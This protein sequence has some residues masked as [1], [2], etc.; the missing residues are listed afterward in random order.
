MRRSGGPRVPTDLADF[1]GQT[2]TSTYGGG[3]VAS[4]V[5]AGSGPNR[6][7][8][9]TWAVVAAA[10]VGAALLATGCEDGPNQTLKPAPSGA[11][12]KWN[13]GKTKG[14][15]DDQA[16][17]GFAADF[18]GGANKQ[19]I[20]TGEQRA[21]RWAKM[22]TEPI[23]PPTKAAGI[24][25]VGG[26]AWTGMTVEQAEK[27]N[28]QS[29]T[30]GDQFGDGTLVNAWGDQGEVWI[31]YDI[32]NHNKIQWI[33]LW[34]G[35]VGS[36]DFTSRNGQ[37]K[38]VIQIGTQITKNGKKYPIDWTDPAK[39]NAVATEIVDALFA[40]YAPDLPAE[41]ITKGGCI[42]N[43][44]CTQTVFPEQG[45]LRIWPLGLHIWVN[46][47]LA[48]QPTPSTFMR[49]DMRLP[50]VMPF[51]LGRPELKLDAVGPTTSIK[52]LGASP[53]KPGKD[54]TISL[55]MTWQALLDGCV[56]VTGDAK[57]DALNYNKLT[58]NITHDAETFVFD[59]SGVD[60]DFVSS[61]LGPFD[62]LRDQDRPVPGDKAARLTF[63]AN[64]LGHFAN[65]WSADD[66][67]NDLHGSGAVYFE[68]AKL[69][70]A[71]IN[72]QLQ[73]ADPAAPTHELGDPACLWPDDLSGFDPKTFDY[74]KNCTGFEGFV[75]A[76]PAAATAT[77]ANPSNRIR[78][79]A[80]AGQ[81]I[82]TLGLKPGKP[83]AAFCMD[84]TGDLQTGYVNCGASDPY[85]RS[86]SLWD[87]S[88]DRVREVLGK[89]DV[90]NLPPEI[91]DRRFYFKMYVYALLKYMMGSSDGQKLDVDAVPVD[92]NELFFDSEGAGQYELAEYVDRRFVSATQEP[93][94]FVVKADILNGTLY[95]YNFDR[96]LNRDEK[97]I[98]TALTENKGDPPGKENDLTLTNVF[99]S[100]VLAGAYQDTATRTAY[101]CATATWKTDAEM[102]DTATACTND[103]GVAQ[104]P[105]LDP[106]YVADPSDK[107]A[108]MV[109]PLL[110][111][112][113]PILAPYKGA[114]AGRSTVF[115]L[116]S[117]KL[118]IQATYPNLQAAKVKINTSSD[119]Y[120][121][122]SAPGTPIEVLVE[123][124][125]PPQPGYGFLWPLNGQQDKLVQAGL[126]DFSG[127][128]T[129]FNLHYQLPAGAPADGT[130]PVNVMAVDSID[131]L[132]E[133]FLCMDPYTRDLLH[134]GMYD[135]VATV[136]DWIDKHPGAQQAC[137]LIVRYSPYANFPD[138]VISTVNGVRIGVT[139]GGGYGRVNDASLWLP[140]EY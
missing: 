28:C 118:E 19:E 47:P 112:G 130:G 13:D 82:G 123:P 65:D 101:Q 89:G 137:G 50:R 6:S 81:I 85:G 119:P 87:T 98:Y 11:A 32:A 138:Y 17:Q 64:T 99:G 70:Q 94:D 103:V 132:G 96:L 83:L 92:D 95:D 48:P 102:Q 43:G 51:T 69:V 12:D 134:V 106:F 58:G 61:A 120:D 60:V 46:N 63:D 54:C 36:L 115:S 25:G 109:M 62:V 73:L 8:V 10:L 14:H 76:M 5:G 107:N 30:Y 77:T 113:K 35:Y 75:T 108:P 117:D 78:L 86:G 74:A 41:D 126:L 27:I 22:V 129:S 52:G 26:D 38:F 139:Q 56:N 68:Y 84:A 88:F 104:L 39:F 55:G 45:A 57:K 2:R 67:T 9:R 131:F 80:A 110:A 127:T 33:S 18:A 100:P 1:C 31:K 20:C 49:I 122:T 15:V 42:G 79:G 124:W 116:G 16:T 29:E 93:L 135:S 37:D 128:T 125:A 121:A 24:D 40:T 91:R 111:G 72:R 140:G 3:R 105:P 71:E 44:H 4:P 34:P 97:A 53:G 23:L 59:S 66:S 136:V 133:V 7:T 21:A 114:F 90:N